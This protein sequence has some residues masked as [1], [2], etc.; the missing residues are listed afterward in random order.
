MYVDVQEGA[1][2]SRNFK[3]TIVLHTVL[4]SLTFSRCINSP[5]C[6]HLDMLVQ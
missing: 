4:S 1:I 6:K 5:G 3:Y 2:G